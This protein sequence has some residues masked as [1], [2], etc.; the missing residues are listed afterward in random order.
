MKI[1]SY[2]PF[3]LEVDGEE[4]ELRIKRMTL[5]E[6]GQ[7]AAR[8]DKMGTPTAYR[9]VSRETSGPEQERKADKKGNLVYVTD[10]ATLAE[11]KIAALTGDELARYKKA[12]ADDIKE[13]R[14]TLAWILAQFVTVSKGLIEELDDGSENTISKGADLARLFGA[15]VDVLLKIL[16]A[17]RVLN[18]LSAEQKKSYKSPF[19]SSPTSTEP[20]QDPPGPKLETIAPSAETE[21]SAAS[22]D[23][24]KKNPSL[25]GS[26]EQSPRDRV[27]SSR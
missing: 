2:Y 26:M 5:D 19:V 1:K 11:Q 4:V 23:A 22:E 12:E 13:G 3:K 17:V 24:S 27:L 10:F 7:F 16:E 8:A 25:S 18:T 9:F 15:R 20:S 14:E 21:D 6:H